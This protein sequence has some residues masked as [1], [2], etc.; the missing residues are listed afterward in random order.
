MGGTFK[1][2]SCIQEATLKIFHL[3]GVCLHNWHYLLTVVA[4]L[5]RCEH[6]QAPYI[7]LPP[8]AA[9]SSTSSLRWSFNRYGFF[10]FLFLSAACS[11]STRLVH[12]ISAAIHTVAI[13]TAALSPHSSHLHKALSIS[14]HLVFFAVAVLVKE[15]GFVA[16]NRRVFRA[17]GVD[18]LRH[19]HAELLGKQLSLGVFVTA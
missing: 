13:Y 18:C 11:C 14:C 17:N 16:I 1:S 3:F 19:L 9:A 8:R 12:Q 4:L 7:Q 15:R 2:R 10:F 6:L 5:G